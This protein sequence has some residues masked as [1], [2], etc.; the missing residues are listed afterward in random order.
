MIIVSPEFGESYQDESGL[1]PLGERLNYNSLFSIFSSV[2]P[3]FRNYSKQVWTYGFNRDYQQSKT[4]SKLPIRDVPKLERHSLRLEK[5]KESRAIASSQ[6]LKLPEKKTLE[7]LE[8]GTRLHKYLEILDF[9]DD[10][11]SLIAS[12]PE[13]ENLKG[14]LRSFFTQDIFK[15][16]IIRTYHE[17]QFRFEKTEI[18]TGSIDLI[19]ETNDELIIIDYKTADLSKP[20]Y[21]R[22]L[23]IYK[24]YLESISTKTVSCYLYSLLEEK[25][26]SVF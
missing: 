13:T 18:I 26:E 11:D 22:Q 6:S 17:Y 21:R 23:A 20:E 14:K 4:I 5:Q 7:N 3:T 10:I 19:L 8:F 12:L 24:E 1:L 16:K 25:M 15:K 2:A 9:Q